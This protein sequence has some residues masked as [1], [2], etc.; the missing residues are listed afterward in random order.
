MSFSKDVK[1]E[2]LR[3]SMVKGCC[4]LA[5]LTAVVRNSAIVEMQK[6]MIDILIQTKN[7]LIARRIFEV[8][9]VL[10]GYTPPIVM[11]KVH[12][13]TVYTVKIDDTDVVRDL[14]K[15][16]GIE[17]YSGAM[18][19][20]R[21]QVSKYCFKAYICGLF[22]VNGS[23]NC[24]NRSYHLEITNANEMFAAEN[25]EILDK[26]GMDFKIVERK[27]IYVLYIKDGESIVDFLNIV[28][29]HKALMEFEN[30]RVVKDVKNNINRVI[31]CETANL[32][33]TVNAS[34]R[35]VRC[36]EYIDRTIG[37][38]KLPHRLREIARIR[39]E[40][41]EL[42]LKDLGQML[43]PVLGKSGVNYRLKKIEQ[44]ATKLMDKAN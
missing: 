1:E 43:T 17:R 19:Y 14:L 18:K 2:I 3:L 9:K 35:Q 41:R 40:N 28:G 16:S 37:I 39:L 38:E 27:G 36:I 12:A 26:V 44:I 30:V 24:P 42:S 11:R 8:V 4:R 25:R 32:E 7:A 22:L 34:V 21:I 33:K 5:W 31:N 20:N 23:I 10:Y 29:A 15:K 13:K 6:D